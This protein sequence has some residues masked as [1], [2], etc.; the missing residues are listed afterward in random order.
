M[1]D[2]RF[3]YQNLITDES[4]IN[5]SSLR[6]GIVT[7]AKKEGIGSATI[8]TSGAYSGSVDLEYIVEIDS[9]AGGAEVGQATFKWSDGGGVWDATGVATSASDVTLNNGV[10]VKWATGSGAD[11]AVGDKWYLKGVNLF[12]PGKMIDLERDHRYRSAALG[13]PNT[14]TINLGSAKAFQA[15]ILYDHNLTSA[16]TITFEADAAATFNSGGGGAPQI[17]ESV[18]WVAEKI[19]HYLATT[20]TKQYARLK[21]TDAANTDGFIEI[22]ELFLGSYMELSGNYGNG[23]QKGFVLL[24]NANGTPYGVNRKRFFNRQRQFTYDYRGLVSADLT[25]LE[26]LVDVIADRDAGTLKPFFFN[27]DS[28]ILANTWM[29]D[30]VGLPEDHM[31]RGYFRTSLQMIEVMK[32]V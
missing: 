28:A 23:Y 10:K 7:G 12:N 6:T 32:S 25:L 11:F 13:S 18:T 17:S 9:I 16:A 1:G 29:V 21:I 19:L 22:G 8:S 3:L 15:L 30:I 5:V 20:V 4:M 2:A 27:D 24:S 14:I 26:G 31:V